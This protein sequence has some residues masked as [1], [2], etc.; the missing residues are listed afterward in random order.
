MHF[1][2]QSSGKGE[3]EK[4]MPQKE[5]RAVVKKFRQGVFN[6]LIATSI[7]EEVHGSTRGCCAVCLL[8]RPMSRS[9]MSIY[10]A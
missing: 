5:Q 4:G 2:G 3:N 9:Y 10:M 8:A 7:G 6:V 1:I